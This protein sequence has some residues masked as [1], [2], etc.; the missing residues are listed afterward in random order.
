MEKRDKQRPN[1]ICDQHA[2]IE[3]ASTFRIKVMVPDIVWRKIAT[4]YHII[5]VWSVMREIVM[6]EGVLAVYQ[7]NDAEDSCCNKT[8]S[9]AAD[10]LQYVL[11]HSL[12][13]PAVHLPEIENKRKQKQQGERA[14]EYKNRLIESLQPDKKHDHT[15]HGGTDKE[16]K[17]HLLD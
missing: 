6:I 13:E 14:K 11:L 10:A 5:V 17:E 8:Q 3:E 12:Y 7:I 16:I 9:A 4:C 2:E 15:Q 1:P